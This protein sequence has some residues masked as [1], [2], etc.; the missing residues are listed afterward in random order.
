MVTFDVVHVFQVFGGPKGVMDCL[1]R[2]TP[3]HG[4]TYSAVQMWKQRKRIP[5]KWVGAIL[6]CVE[7]SGHH[8]V[9]FLTDPDELTAQ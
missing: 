3:N 9:E 1:D 6:Y 4:L 7:Q 8:C 5:T 2:Y